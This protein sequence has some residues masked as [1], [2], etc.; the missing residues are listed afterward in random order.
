MIQETDCQQ[1]EMHQKKVHSVEHLIVSIHQP[2]AITIVRGK[3][4]AKTKSGSKLYLSLISELPLKTIYA[5]MLTMREH[6]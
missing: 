5:G 1:K 4:K 6:C 2:H 3:E